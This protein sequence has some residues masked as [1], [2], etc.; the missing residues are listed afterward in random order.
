M[1]MHFHALKDCD[2][3]SELSSL[4]EINDGIALGGIIGTDGSLALG[5]L[6]SFI[7]GSLDSSDDGLEDRNGTRDS[8]R[9]NGWYYR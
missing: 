3:G 7:D 8:R 4:D 5:S 9:N 6:N 2:D 1:K